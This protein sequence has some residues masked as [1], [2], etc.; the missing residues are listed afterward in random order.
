MAE[1]TIAS[2]K[3]G[4]PRSFSEE[5]ALDAAMR[6][7]WEKGYEGAS[8][9]DLTEAMGINR[10][11]LYATF[12]DKQALFLRAMEQ[13]ANGP[14]HYLRAALDQRSAHGVIEALL[15]GA[16]KLLADPRNPRGC[17]SVQ[18]GT[19]C[20]TAAEPIKQ[21][22]IAW[23]KKGE[24]EIVKRFKRARAEGDLPAEL[25]PQDLARYLAAV[26]NGLGIQAANGATKAEMTRVVEMA[27]RA[28]PKAN[29]KSG[30]K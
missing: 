25:D 30:T 28:L 2:A 24:A 11:S 15:H 8:V 16:V 21:A 26:L 10:P 14:A 19:A 18:G 22:L 4:R 7:F 29:A 23:R 6:V 9:A 3:L 17:L 12:G 20:G 27:L 1:T 13:Y 5:A